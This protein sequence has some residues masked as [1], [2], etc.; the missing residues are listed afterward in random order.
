MITYD[1]NMCNNVQEANAWK[2]GHYIEC[3]WKQRM[4][5]THQ[6]YKLA[7]HL[8]THKHTIFLSIYMNQLDGS[9]NGSPC[10]VQLYLT[11]A[12]LRVVSW[13]CSTSARKRKGLFTF[14]FVDDHS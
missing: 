1:R 11:P 9:V 2:K 5:F 8:H 7:Q 12:A 4:C 14:A 6:A 10:I 3:S 13:K